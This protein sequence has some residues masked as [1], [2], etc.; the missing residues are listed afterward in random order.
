MDYEE[1]SLRIVDGGEDMNL[2][3][4]LE[5]AVAITAQSDDRGSSRVFNFV[6]TRWLCASPILGIDSWICE[7]GVRGRKIRFAVGTKWLPVWEAWLAFDRPNLPSACQSD[8]IVGQKMF[9]C[10]LFRLDQA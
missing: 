5:I 9:H 7:R 10:F 8:L 2:C 3:H 1:G 6:T 4:E